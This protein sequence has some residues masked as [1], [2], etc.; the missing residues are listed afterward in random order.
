MACGWPGTSAR[1]WT[2][3]RAGRPVPGSCCG[4]R[5]RTLRGAPMDPFDGSPPRPELRF[6]RMGPANGVTCLAVAGEVDMTTGELFER[7]LVGALGEPGVT[8]VL[9]DVAP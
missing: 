2:S 7:T 8:R 6:E 1:A 5:C 3:R 9:L 4:T